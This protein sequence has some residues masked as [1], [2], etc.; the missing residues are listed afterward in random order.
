MVRR[1]LN[2]L[3]RWGLR[4]G[5]ARLLRALMDRGG[6]QALES[7]LGTALTLVPRPAERLQTQVFRV[8]PPTTVYLRASHC[9]VTVRPL[10]DSRVILETTRHPVLGP[11]LT[12]DQDAAGVYIVARRKPVVGAAS[13]AELTLLVPPDTHLALH[14]TPGEIT[15][16]C[17][18]GLVDLPGAVIFPPPQADSPA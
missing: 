8:T 16:E 6:Q 1:I 17:I 4:S 12:T 14:L 18:E 9:H 10:I 5:G 2:H 15:F 7:A 3:M 13:R 11:D